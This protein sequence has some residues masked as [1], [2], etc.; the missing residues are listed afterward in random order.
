MPCNDYRRLDSAR[1]VSCLSFQFH[2]L[3]DWRHMQML[4]YT[5]QAICMTRSTYTSLNWLVAR[6][7][8]GP[9]VRVNNMQMLFIVAHIILSLNIRRVFTSG[10]MWCAFA[11]HPCVSVCH[12]GGW[13]RLFHAS[14]HF[15]KARAKRRRN[16][17]FSMECRLE[18]TGFDYGMQSRWWSCGCN[19]PTNKH[20][21]N[22]VWHAI[23][24][25]C[26]LYIRHYQTLAD[27]RWLFGHLFRSHWLACDP[28]Y[29][30]YSPLKS[31][32]NTFKIRHTLS[33]GVD[34]TPTRY[35]YGFSARTGY[36]CCL[37]ILSDH[38]QNVH[39]GAKQTQPTRRVLPSVYS[40]S[41]RQVIKSIHFFLLLRNFGVVVCFYGANVIL[42]CCFSVHKFV[43]FLIT[44]H[45]LLEPIFALNRCA[46]FR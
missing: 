40:N 12:C 25:G 14:C 7:S 45:L 34:G 30:C 1:K 10:W 15:L 28:P 4:R 6:I 32:I 44:Y 24:H 9:R 39:T 37:N 17:H 41:D 42:C 8:D 33:T 46:T 16:L 43:F 2:F 18:I 23:A 27:F 29:R 35:I 5:R 36:Q 3:C 31:T 26:Q 13:L 20:R 11:L 19:L 38:K 21:D 22:I